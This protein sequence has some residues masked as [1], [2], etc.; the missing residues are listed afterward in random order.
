[1][2]STWSWNY[3]GGAVAERRPA[4]ATSMEVTGCPTWRWPDT[5]RTRANGR[6]HRADTRSSRTRS[7]TPIFHALTRGGL[8]SQR[9]EPAP[10]RGATPADPV[11]TFQ[12]D[13]LTAP[14]PVQALEAVP[15]PPWR[16]ALAELTPAGRRGG[17]GGPSGGGTTAGS[18][19]WPTD[20]AGA[21]QPRRRAPPRAG[22]RWQPPVHPGRLAVGEHL[23]A[24]HPDV[25][26]DPGAAGPHQVRQQL[27]VV[28][29]GDERGVAEVDVHQVGPAARFE[30]AEVVAPD[31]APRRPAWP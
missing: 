3:V 10:R 21:D 17:A 20:P 6:C 11:A 24:G 18:K 9:P 19:W 12:R 29:G 27:R 8:R 30:R 2:P 15:S 7:S 4:Q 28:L 26:H 25:P 22:R 5:T 31:R 16:R 23:L 1:M 14:I 13:P